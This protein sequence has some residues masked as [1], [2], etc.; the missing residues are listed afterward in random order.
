MIPSRIKIRMG[1]IRMLA[2]T[3]SLKISFF[4]LQFITKE[5]RFHAKEIQ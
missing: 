5:R 2:G 1:I 4:T 3:G